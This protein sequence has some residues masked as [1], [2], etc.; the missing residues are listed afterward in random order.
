MC[1]GI[2]EA[3]SGLYSPENQKQKTIPMPE[4]AK[5][6]Q[7]EPDMCVLDFSPPSVLAEFACARICD[8]YDD[9][10]VSGH[11]LKGKVEE[12]PSVWARAIQAKT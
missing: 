5:T 10:S 4:Q 9:I 3:G 1:G 6:G 12:F 11:K 2:L 7:A 8:I